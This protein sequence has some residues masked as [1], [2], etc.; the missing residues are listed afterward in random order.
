MLRIV[1]ITLVFFCQL[2]LAE[3][4]LDFT[5]ETFTF[6]QPVDH[7]SPNGETFEQFYFVLTPNM[8]DTTDDIDVLF[9][10]G[11]ENDATETRLAKIYQAYGSPQD[12]VFVLAEHRGYGESL[13]GT[14]QQKPS[15][16]SMDLAAADDHRIIQHLRQ[17]YTGKWVVNGCSYGGSLVIR[18][19][20][21]YPDTYDVV[22]SSSAV[23]SYPLL[24]YP[25]AEKL[26]ETFDA[27]TLARIHGHINNLYSKRQDPE[28]VR[29]MELV[30]TLII[31]IAQ[32]G[33]MEYLRPVAKYLSYLPTSA[34]VY[35]ID[36]L[37][38]PAAH[39]WANGQSSFTVPATP[40]LRN[41]YTWKYQQCY[42]LGTFM[43]GYPFVLTEEDYRQRCIQTFG[44]E[45]PYFS[46]PE[47]SMD[48]SLRAITKPTIIISGGQDPWINVGVKPD[49]DYPN[50][51]YLYDSEWHHCPDKDTPDA[52]SAL[53]QTLNRLLNK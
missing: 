23:M 13:Y 42:E 38:P 33:P 20:E 49:H 52:S 28:S 45:P 51:N 31:A 14:S 4:S 37:M 8:L 26:V 2:A 24:N 29:Q 16:V 9:I 47:R 5:V 19:A 50:I 48:S 53:I 30:H 3:E 44:E 21:L 35:V 11:N 22:I 46:A 27:H 17:K 15:Y 1:I 6:T 34:L 32:I 7:D 10:L 36:K 43:A 40:Q 12:M 39:N 41:W 25:Y 18:Y